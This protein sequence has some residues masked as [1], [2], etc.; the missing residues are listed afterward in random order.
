MLIDVPNMEKIKYGIIGCGRHALRS[1]A[2]P[3][4]DTLGL[5]ISLQL[6]AICDLSKEQLDAFEASYGK[7]L[8]KFIDKHEF[9]SIN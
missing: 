8:S 4:R 9:L 6:E 3:A 5:D 1:H 7:K 2:I